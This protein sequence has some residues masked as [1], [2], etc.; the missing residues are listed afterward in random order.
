[1]KL[2]DYKK[3]HQIQEEI[4]RLKYELGVLKDHLEN[5]TT[6]RFGTNF[7]V[8]IPIKLSD[9]VYEDF[10]KKQIVFHEEQINKLD[11]EFENI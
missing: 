2:Q 11:I 1:M 9:S 6:I 4:S 3:A 5:P 8:S 10:I 7:N